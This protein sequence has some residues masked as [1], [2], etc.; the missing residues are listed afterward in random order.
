VKKILM[1]EYPGMPKVKMPCVDVRNVALAHLNGLKNENAA[2]KR[3]I[4]CGDSVW[5]SDLGKFLDEKYHAS[6][7][8]PT[9]T[10]SKFFCKI[11]SL[12][13]KDLK[14]VMPMWGVETVYVNKRA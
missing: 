8:P 9:K 1:R 6:Y 10:L 4:L 5:F 14:A 11:G 7:H 3:F 12:F 2:N 13:I